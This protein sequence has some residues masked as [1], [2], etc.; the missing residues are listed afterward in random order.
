MDRAADSAMQRVGR[1]VWHYIASSTIFAALAYGVAQYVAIQSGH[2]L[3]LGGY[4]YVLV[5]LAMCILVGFAVEEARETSG[6]R[7][8]IAV[9][10]VPLVVICAFALMLLELAAVPQTHNSVELEDG[11]EFLLATASKEQ[12][13]EVSHQLLEPSR[14][15]PLVWKRSDVSRSLIYSESDEPHAA[16]SGLLETPELVLDGEQRYLLV[17]RGRLWTDC[18]EIAQEL[19]PCQGTKDYLPEVSD[20]WERRSARIETVTGQGPGTN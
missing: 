4:S 12:T 18:L 10:K 1:S 7:R 15:F 3:L 16:E 17:R 14:L 19:M 2:Y 8:C 6:L 11:R 13:S 20:A 5:L 9:A